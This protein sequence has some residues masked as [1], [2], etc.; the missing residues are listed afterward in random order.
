MTT[1]ISPETEAD[2]LK[3]AWDVLDHSYSPYSRF[4][5][6]AALQTVSGE[7]FV[8][9]NVECASFADCVCAERSAIGAAVSNGHQDFVA[10]A[11]VTQA[12]RPTPP[13]GGCRQLLAEF[14][15]DIQV[16]YADKND[17]RRRRVREL[18]PDMFDGKVLLDLQ[19]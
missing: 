16:V 2:L 8:G 4:K 5:V 9:V 18:L 17:I 19:I 3:R 15:L 14:G 7:V 11:I 13:C 12:P 6:G 10:I 1:T